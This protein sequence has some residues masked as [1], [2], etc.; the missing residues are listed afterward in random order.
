MFCGFFS[1]SMI[2]SLFNKKE[3]NEKYLN[4]IDTHVYY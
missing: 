2:L 3:N 1:I 4:N